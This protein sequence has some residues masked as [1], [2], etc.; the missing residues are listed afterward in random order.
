MAL[1]TLYCS[2]LVCFAWPHS[3]FPCPVISSVGLL[4]PARFRPPSLTLSCFTLPCSA[5]P[6]L[7]VCLPTLR[8]PILTFPSLTQVGLPC[9]TL[10]Q[11]T[12]RHIVLFYSG[13][14]FTFLVYQS[15]SCSVLFTHAIS[16]WLPEPSLQVQ[17]RKSM[18]TR[19]LPFSFMTYSAL[20]SLLYSAL[21]F[22]TLA[23]LR[24]YFS[25]L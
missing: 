13:M 5:L 9:S 25:L 6:W 21:T 10:L 17:E 1:P 19:P 7:V 8:F 23:G 4:H 24:S 15:L 3:A 11:P 16:T 2:R 18:G 12:L 22:C 20:P 14:L